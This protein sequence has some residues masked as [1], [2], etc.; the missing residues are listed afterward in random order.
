MST[1]PPTD[2]KEFI[3]KLTDRLSRSRDLAISV[4]VHFILITIF[5]TTVLFHAVQEPE[6]I[7]GHLEVASAPTP[8]MPVAPAAP[9]PSQLDIL[10]APTPNALPTLDAIISTTPNPLNFVVSPSV[11]ASSID[12]PEPTAPPGDVRTTMTNGTSLSPEQ[13]GEIYDLSKDWVKKGSGGGLREKE[14]VF[15]AFVLRYQGGDWNSTIRVANNR[16]ET[17]SLPNLLYLMSFWSKDKITTNYRNVEVIDLTSEAGVS[18]LF[19]EKPPFVFLSGTRDFVLTDREVE[20]LQRY[21]RMGGCIWG[22]A[23]L[24]GQKS[25][26]DN[27]FRREMRR[28]IPD[29]DKD[30]EPLPANHPIFTQGYFAN[31]KELPSGINF[32][33]D[34]IEVLRFFG[35][36]AVI[37]SS[38][39][40]GDMWQIGLNQQGQIDTRR[41]ERNQYVAINEQIYNNRGVYVRNIT[42]SSLKAS[43]EFG[44]NVVIHLLTRWEDKVRAAPTL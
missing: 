23:S 19:E 9:E 28:V 15:K 36:I 1:S 21:I 35:E 18:K 8:R 29:V 3:E 13:A 17:G 42:P 11:L 24:P 6:E 33:R 16:V 30:F 25:R 38:N 2:S 41:N 22:D 31:I 44:T 27:A 37:Y 43:F 14:F 39:D 34:P 7:E 20:T 26:F 4:V 32:Y 10:K 5:G 40:Y 12:R